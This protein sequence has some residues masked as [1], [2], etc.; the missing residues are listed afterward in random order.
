MIIALGLYISESPYVFKTYHEIFTY[1]II[2]FKSLVS[3][4]AKNGGGHGIEDSR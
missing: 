2:Y 1:E 4:T 3:H